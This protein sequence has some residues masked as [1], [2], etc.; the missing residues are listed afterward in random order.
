MDNAR[1]KDAQFFITTHSPLFAILEKDIVSTHV[2][3]RIHGISRAKQLLHY[4][5]YFDTEPII[6][7]DG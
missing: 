3:T 4:L 5:R 7:G 6:I 1:E 2:I